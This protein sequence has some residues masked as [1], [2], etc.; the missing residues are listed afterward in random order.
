LQKGVIVRPVASYA[1]PTY[2]RIS[3]GTQPQN[4]A[5]LNALE[6]ALVALN[7]SAAS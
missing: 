5:F 2:L 6:T 7:S 3:I 1:M 4:A